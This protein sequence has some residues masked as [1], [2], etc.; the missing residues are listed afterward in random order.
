MLRQKKMGPSDEAC[1][2]L[3]KSERLRLYMD[4]LSKGARH[5]VHDKDLLI[6]GETEEVI[7]CASGT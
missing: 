7:G 6:D 2:E 3:E 4:E 5:L 1:V